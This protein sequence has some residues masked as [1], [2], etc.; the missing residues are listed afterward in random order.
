MGLTN[1]SRALGRSSLLLISQKLLTLS[2]IPPFSTNLFQLA[3][4]LALLVERNL[5]FL[6]G[7]LGWFIKITKVTSFGS[8]AVFGPVL[9]SP[10]M[11]L[12]AS[13]P[14]SVSCSLYA[15]NLAIWSSSPSVPTAVEATQGALFRLGACLSTSVFLSIRANVRPP[16]I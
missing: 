9:F 15:D 8:V 13:L 10:S 12:P 7:S 14:S 2:G 5:F 3:S 11:D 16:S 1:P 6:I 4:L